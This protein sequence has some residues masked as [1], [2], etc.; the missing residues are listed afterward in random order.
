[1]AENHLGSGFK[2]WT[3]HPVDVQEGMCLSPILED[4]ASTHAFMAFL[5]WLHDILAILALGC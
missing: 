3:C 1:M 2:S 4:H 5:L